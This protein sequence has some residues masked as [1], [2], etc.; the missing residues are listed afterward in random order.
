[1]IQ[2]NEETSFDKKEVIKRIKDNQTF[3]TNKEWNDFI[4]SQP[5][6]VIPMVVFSLMVLIGILGLII[7]N[8]N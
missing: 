4:L 3:M 2:I 8:I 7:I 6:F 5:E 1:M